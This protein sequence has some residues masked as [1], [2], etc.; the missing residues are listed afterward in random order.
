[1]NIYATYRLRQAT[2]L[3]ARLC[4]KELL[5]NKVSFLWIAYF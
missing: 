4:L 2:V 3:N 5:H 1:M